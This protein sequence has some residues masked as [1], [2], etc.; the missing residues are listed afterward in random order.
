MGRERGRGLADGGR[1]DDRRGRVSI[2][3]QVDGPTE[4]GLGFDPRHDGFPLEGLHILTEISVRSLRL[5]LGVEGNVPTVVVR[6]LETTPRGTVGVREQCFYFLELNMK[7]NLQL[8]ASKL[9]I[10]CVKNLN[11]LFTRS[12]YHPNFNQRVADM[13]ELKKIHRILV[14]YRLF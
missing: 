12:L 11:L 3:W 10:R 13:F 6:K 1:C 9:R 2:L 5:L 4:Q 7:T 14:D 8:C